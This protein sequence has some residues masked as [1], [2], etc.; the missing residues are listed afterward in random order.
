M[1]GEESTAAI[2]AAIDSEAE[3]EHFEFWATRVPTF[4]LPEH[5]PFILFKCCECGPRYHGR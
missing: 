1:S 4:L 3:R 2:V 5:Y